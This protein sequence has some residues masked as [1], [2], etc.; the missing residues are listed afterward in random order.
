MYIESPG[1]S[2]RS[3]LPVVGAWLRAVWIQAAQ[4]SNADRNRAGPPSR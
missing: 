2:K 3:R 1:T 4:V